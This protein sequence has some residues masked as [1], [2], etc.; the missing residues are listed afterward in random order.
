MPADNGPT[1]YAGSKFKVQRSERATWNAEPRTRNPHAP[2]P[3]AHHGAVMPTTGSINVA[4]Q[5]LLTPDEVAAT[6]QTGPKRLRH[7]ADSW[8][9]I[10]VS[11][12]KRRI[13][14]RRLL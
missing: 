5:L 1:G 9:P 11:A 8:E 4:S 6:S 10:Q 3:S 7:K 2:S 14:P 13:F 12:P